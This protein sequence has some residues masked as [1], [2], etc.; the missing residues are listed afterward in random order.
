M[1]LD[2]GKGHYRVITQLKRKVPGLKIMLSV[3]GGIDNDPDVDTNK[4]L[5]LLESVAGRSAFIN[6]AYSLIKTYDFDGIDLAWQFPPNKPKKI[7][8]AI[9]MSQWLEID[10]Q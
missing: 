5:T 8:N 4:Y 3:G 1:D 9:S 6:S 10:R 7:R 2:K